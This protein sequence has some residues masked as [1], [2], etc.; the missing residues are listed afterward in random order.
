MNRTDLQRLA[1]LRLRE[2]EALIA[3][4]EWSGAYYLAGYAVECALKARIAR[5]VRRHEFPDRNRVNK[6]Y[7]HD[8]DAL[9]T[10]A[11]LRDPLT[12]ELDRDAIF[13]ASWLIVKDWREDSRYQ[14]CGE[15]DARGLVRAI[16]RRGH[17]V[18]QWIR[19]YW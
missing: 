2:A 12:K 14:I 1:R 13:G 5:Q 18:L 16:A 15:A 6:S 19:H 10:V 3:R 17:G 7:T 11:G 8:L 9:V 4:G